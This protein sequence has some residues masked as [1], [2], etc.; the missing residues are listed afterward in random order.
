MIM[1]VRNECD[2]IRENIGF[3]LARGVDFIL[4]TDNGSDDG[5]RDILAGFEAEGVLR[6]IDEPEHTFK[7]GPWM[8]RMAQMA[9][10]SYGAD[11]I[12]NNDADEFWLPRDG[13][14]KMA[15]PC[16]DAPDMLVC[17]RRNMVY[18]R[19]GDMS[20]PW[21]SRAVYRR[22]APLPLTPLADPM[23]DPLPEPYFC[24][25]LP[26]KVMAR[27]QGLQSIKPGNHGALFRHKA[28]SAPAAVTIYHYPVRSPDQ[29]RRKIL[30]GGAAQDANPTLPQSSGWHWR[31]WYAMMQAGDVD[32]PFRE[33]LPDAA[34]I[35]A[36][37]DC[38]AMV[39][40]HTMEPLL[41]TPDLVVG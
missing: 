2:I 31:R 16:S 23:R 14:L 28:S 6:V 4:V 22:A 37:L 17:K 27:T 30:N 35:A 39:R 19:D 41:P 25:D 15:I 12:L 7:Q 20:L 26:P 24:L 1:V 21:Q 29:I 18:A 32:A 38:G 10:D 40:D 33:A 11:W 9:R 8:T 34:G 36:D 5:T 13:N 3:H